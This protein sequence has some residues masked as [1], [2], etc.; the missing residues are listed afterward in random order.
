MTKNEVRMMWIYM[1]EIWP[2]FPIPD[3]ADLRTVKERVWLDLCGDLAPDLVRATVASM[4]AR[5]FPP[6]PGLVQEE[7]HR[8]QA[9]S[10]GEVPMPGVD[11]AWTEFKANYRTSGPWS[12]PAIAAAANALGC[13]EF[14]ASE[15]KDEIGQRAH[16]VK[17][18]GSAS[19]RIGRELG[20]MPP[21]LA[22]YMQ[23]AIKRAPQGELESAQ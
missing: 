23:S 4:A 6:T 13:R 17:F 7:A 10:R 19:L 21:V 18:Y 8:I 12:H 16:F 15:M 22:A 3:S 1:Q 14:G 20:E 11:E 2:N 9:I 5:E